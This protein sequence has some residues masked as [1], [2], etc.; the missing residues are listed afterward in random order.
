V[1]PSIPIGTS[2]YSRAVLVDTGAFIALADSR[3][4]NHQD[5]IDCLAKINAFRFP[6]FVPLPIIYETQKRLL[7]DLG[8][9]AAARFLD[10]IFDG[11]V[12]VIRTVD[13]DETEAK[14]LITRYL[15]LKLTLT[16]AVCMA[17]MRRLG[18]AASF[19]F[20]RHFLQA[21][22]IRVPPFHI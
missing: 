2:L 1:P 13:S 10:S 19:S 8:Q 12:A 20:D 17:I 6:V 9:G 3:D 22:F 14:T 18:I 16:D 21:G 5:A 15:D 11:S 7:F 4:V